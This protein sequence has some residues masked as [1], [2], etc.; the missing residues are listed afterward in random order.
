M[1]LASPTARTVGSPRRSRP[2]NATVPYLTPTG[3]A[4]DPTLR[5]YD[6]VGRGGVRVVTER[7]SRSGTTADGATRHDGTILP[8]S[9]TRPSRAAHLTPGAPG[10]LAATA[11]VPAS[12]GRDGPRRGNNGRVALAARGLFRVWPAPRGSGRRRRAGRP[13]SSPRRP[14]GRCAHIARP[15]GG[16][17]L[18]VAWGVRGR[19]ILLSRA[20]AARER[21]VVSRSR[22]PFQHRMGAIGAASG[23]V[24]ACCRPMFS[25]FA[26]ETPSTGS[27]SR[28]AGRSSCSI[29]PT[30]AWSKT[31]CT[32]PG[33]STGVPAYFATCAAARRTT[34]WL[35][36]VAGSRG[37]QV[38]PRRGGNPRLI[39]GVRRPAQAAAAD[40]R[41]RP[42]M[43]GDLSRV[44]LQLNGRYTADRR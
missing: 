33:P 10:N 15:A 24:V 28:L 35:V 21:A 9:H 31:R 2:R 13:P 41:H 26:A 5:V 38:R 20:S 22:R 43:A 42:D 1:P 16:S 19:C 4:R 6:G 40:A 37:P 30:G 36:D 39:E 11:K 29:T 34:A 27:T 23:I 14:G 32:H 18:L 3:R 7:A 25:S 12:S 8:Q 44:L 17:W